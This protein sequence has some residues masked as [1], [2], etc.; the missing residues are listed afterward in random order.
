[1]FTKAIVRRPCRNMV[2]GITSAPQLGLPDYELALEQH[3][4]YI[5]ALRALGLAVTVLPALEDYPDSCFVEDPAVLN[6]NCALLT[7]PGAGSRNLEREHMAPVLAEF[8]PP[9]QQRRISAPATVEGGDVMLAGAH[10]Y[11][12]RSQRTNAEGCRQFSAIMQDQGYQVTTVEMK[13]FLHLKT[14]LSY[15]EN[16]NLLVCGEFVEHPLFTGF[17]RIIVPDEEAYAANSLWINGTVLTPQG[18]PLTLAKIRA[19]GY[20]TLVLDVSEFR[21]LDGGLSCLSLRF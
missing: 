7:N 2:R 6:P 11:I 8:Y 13:E 9:D 10:Y 17:N 15:L 21:K 20:P 16:N 5:D 18:F 4:R 1:M 14:G 19:A 12:G 3:T